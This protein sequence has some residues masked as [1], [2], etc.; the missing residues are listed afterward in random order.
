MKASIFSCYL[1]APLLSLWLISCATIFNGKNEKIP[2]VGPNEPVLIEAN[3]E[4]LIIYQ[5]A[6]LSRY[7]EIPR[8]V[9]VLI[10]T[11]FNKKTDSI[12]LEPKLQPGWIVG[13]FF[14]YGV[15]AIIDDATGSWNTFGE[16][17]I[18]YGIADSTLRK[19]HAANTR[20]H[21][22]YLE[23]IDSTQFRKPYKP[24]GV[25]LQATFGFN[26]ITEQVP[27][28]FPNIGLI[29][30]YNFNKYFSTSLN[31]DLNGCTDCVNYQGDI[32]STGNCDI[33]IEHYSFIIRGE[34]EGLYLGL[35]GGYS[36]IQSPTMKNITTQQKV[37]GFAVTTP[38][39]GWSIGYRGS[40]G[41]MEYRRLFGTKRFS[42]GED[43][44]AAL[45]SYTL[46]GGIGITF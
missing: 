33:T 43:A 10:T 41:F 27:L 36:E 12:L 42:V 45:R 5:R 23:E 20:R 22:Q 6:D 26:S 15:S 2:V 18:F 21:I 44:T 16:P 11:T 3:G 13:A 46:R 14:T 9:P 38:S 35:H 40:V 24:V 32:R 30:G 1:C 34:L 31:Y 28:L 8:K 4:P 29:M 19:M 37:G 39:Y 25:H 17:I 7:V